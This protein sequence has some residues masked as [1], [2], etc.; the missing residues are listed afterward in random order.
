MNKK[1]LFLSQKTPLANERILL[2]YQIPLINFNEIDLFLLFR[3][4][5]WL[6]SHLLDVIWL[7]AIP[8]WL[9][10]YCWEI[11]PLDTPPSRKALD[12]FTPSPPDDASVLANDKKVDVWIWEKLT[13][14]YALINEYS[15][16]F[17][18]YSTL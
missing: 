17:I 14:Q 7:Y 8:L 18:I 2:A 6:V 4:G 12:E 1:S 5:K 9:Y 3:V 13:Q 11:V 16:L 10:G 15:Y